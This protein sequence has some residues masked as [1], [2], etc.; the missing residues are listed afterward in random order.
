[1]ASSLATTTRS[2]HGSTLP[3][4]QG[5]L[6]GIRQGKWILKPSLGP[7]RM[8]GDRWVT[9]AV[10]PLGMASGRLDEVLAIWVLNSRRSAV[11]QSTESKEDADLREGKGGM[12]GKE[13]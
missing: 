12:K 9:A 11:T 2:C 3:V 4:L 13:C 1:M 5:D 8:N 6:K 10:W 7:V